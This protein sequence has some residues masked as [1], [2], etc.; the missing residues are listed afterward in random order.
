MDLEKIAQNLTNNVPKICLKRINLSNTTS[1]SIESDSKGEVLD[2]STEKICQ[3]D[4]QPSLSKITLCDTS[5]ESL[6]N[7]IV[8]STVVNSNN[9]KHH[10]F[11]KIF[12]SFKQTKCQ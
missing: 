9:I 10:H 4:V 11:R 2:E 8:D 1:S 3:Q 6:N 7:K 5:V 12:G